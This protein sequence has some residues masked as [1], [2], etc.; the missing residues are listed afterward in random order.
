MRPH[1]GVFELPRVRLPREV[2]SQYN[3]SY[4]CSNEFKVQEMAQ[5]TIYLDADAERRLKAAARKAGV[6][7]SRWVG[8]LVHNRTR[9]EWPAEARKLAGAWPDFPDL[10]DLRAVTG[11]DQ[12]RGRL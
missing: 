3:C 7:V 9:S 1:L 11:K 5:V 2:Q 8:D 4:M 6:S 12:P 10:R